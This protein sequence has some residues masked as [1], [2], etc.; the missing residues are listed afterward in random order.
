MHV[1]GINLV[2]EQ[3]HC[4]F[5]SLPTWLGAVYS[6]TKLSYSHSHVLEQVVLKEAG[7]AL[8]NV[9]NSQKLLLKSH[10]TSTRI[11][12]YSLGREEGKH[13]SHGT[14]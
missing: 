13:K 11:E 10:C 9:S 8:Q 12:Q 2:Y 4:P 1:G 7:L 14:G 5:S 3:G 6:W